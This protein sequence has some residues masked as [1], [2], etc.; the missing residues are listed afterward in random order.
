MGPDPLAPPLSPRG[1]EG[2]LLRGGHVLGE[3]GRGIQPADVLIQGDRIREVGPGLTPPA[4]VQELDASG[5]LVLPGLVNAHTHAHNNLLKGLADRW[6]LEDL[7]NHS[8][9]LNAGRTVEDQYLSAAIGAVEMLKTGCTA[10]YDLFMATPAPTDEGVEAVARAYAD[11]GLR[12]LVA[13]AVADIVFYQTVPGLLDRLP[14][15]LRATVEG[16]TAAPTDALLRLTDAAVRRWHGAA[17]GRIRVAVAPTIPGMCTDAFLEGCARLVREHGVGVHTHLLESKVQAVYA[18]RRWGGSVVTRLADVGLLGPSFVG[19][20]AVWLTDEDIGRLAD[21]GGAVAHNPASNFKLGSGIAPVREYLDRGVTVGLGTDGTMSSD[22]LN[23]F[24][25]MRLAALAG[26]VRFPHA[27]DRW[28][29]APAV[30]RMAT[31]G[32]AALLGLRDEVGAV[33]PRFKADLVLLRTDSTFLRPLNHALHALIFAETGAD[34]DTV[35]V[36]GR[37]VVEG[38][39]VV[40]VDEE[41]LRARAQAAAERVRGANR[42]AF[43]F[44]AELAP[45]LGSA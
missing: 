40:T 28:L 21:A 3:D 16:L 10:A 42:A 27:P 20:H 9:A 29:D 4:G 43:A 45:H 36:D 24:E 5:R 8:A 35:L 22:N 37:V 38:G 30:W 19:A 33:A 7:L 18:H 34:V 31:R 1:G 17:G 6:T 41:K 39:R 26:T 15:A 25:A 11:V 12:A 23:L 32:G 2:I 14:P 13:P 44:A